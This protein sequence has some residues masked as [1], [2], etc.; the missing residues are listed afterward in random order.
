MPTNRNVL[1]VRL[2]VE[3]ESVCI[4]ILNFLCSS[5]VNTI[6]VFHYQTIA[7]THPNTKFLYFHIHNLQPNWELYHKDKD[8][9]AFLKF[10][11]SLLLAKQSSRIHYIYTYLFMY[12]MN[13][14]D[15]ANNIYGI[16]WRRSHLVLEL[17]ILFIILFTIS[18]FHITPKQYTQINQLFTITTLHYN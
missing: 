3:P 6:F 14:V 17:K 13:K 7:H 4:W 1:S 8:V 2:F 10:C 12:I 18:V 5:G 16:E 11:L 9:W 15:S